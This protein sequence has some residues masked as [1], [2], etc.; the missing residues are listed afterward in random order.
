MTSTH[1]CDK[2]RAIVAGRIIRNV[3]ICHE[4]FRLTIRMDGFPPSAAGQ[5]VQL[6]CR[7]LDDQQSARE[8][9][10]PA[11]G[12][13]VA[14]HPE[15]TNREPMLRRPLS[16]ADR[17][18]LPDGSSEIDIIYRTIGAGTKWLS[19]AP[20]GQQ[21]SVIGPLGNGFTIRPDKA[22]AAVVGGGVGV[23]PMLYM[24]KA[25]NASGR[26]AA[27]F[28]G[29]RTASMLPLTVDG[30]PDPAGSPR[31][32]VSEFSACCTDASIATDDGSAG[33][34]GLVSEAFILWLREHDFDPRDVV[35]YCCG[36]EPMERAVADICLMRGIECQVA[37]ERHMACGMGTCQ[38][39][40]VK[41][42][43]P[44][45]ATGWSFKLCCS[46]GPVFDAGNLLW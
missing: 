26:A 27:A 40:V 16:L 37:L 15:L 3:N 18:D 11:A 38:S 34:S 19:T 8:I 12:L 24:A 13:P 9:A 39:C 44:D 32:C 35:V 30:Q 31:P 2:P 20:V 5:F 21:L 4:H 43:T 17:R 6:Q 10:W 7:G 41:V 14:T 1:Q 22:F 42:R 23:P 36:P 28:C 29:A 46:D 25:L 45:T 33:F